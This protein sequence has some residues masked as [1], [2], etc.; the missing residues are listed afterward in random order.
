MELGDMYQYVLL[1]DIEIYSAFKYYDYFH[2][3]HQMDTNRKYLCLK[4]Q[5]FH[6]PQ[7]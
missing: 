6:L 2:L 1:N 5:M 7:I 4:S 3:R